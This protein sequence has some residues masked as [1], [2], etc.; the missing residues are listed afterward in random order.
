MTEAATARALIERGDGRLVLDGK[1]LVSLPA[2]ILIR[3]T[4]RAI[5][6]VGSGTSPTRLRLERLERLCAD[7][8]T[9]LAARRPISRTL[10]GAL[11]W[12]RSDVS[13]IVEREAARK[14]A[15]RAPA[16]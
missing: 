2:E 4:A 9:A 10:A 11:V 8:A 6:E 3:V 1:E 15:G 5:E 14:R 12:T 7:L 13:L 16:A